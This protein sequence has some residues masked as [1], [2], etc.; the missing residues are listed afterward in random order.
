MYQG[1]HQSR[2]LS[3]QPPALGHLWASASLASHL[4]GVDVGVWSAEWYPLG[5]AW[6]L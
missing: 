2:L 6:R 5:M 3:H 4:P 1:C